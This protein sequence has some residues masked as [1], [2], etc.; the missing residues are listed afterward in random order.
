MASSMESR[1]FETEHR[2]T[3]RPCICVNFA[4]QFDFSSSFSL[5]YLACDHF[6]LAHKVIRVNL[7]TRGKMNY[8]LYS[9]FII[10]RSNANLR[11]ILCSIFII[12]RFYIFILSKRLSND[13]CSMH[14]V[15]LSDATWGNESVDCR[16]R[17]TCN[18]VRLTEALASK[19]QVIDWS[20]RA[21]PTVHGPNCCCVCKDRERGLNG[22]SKILVCC[23]CAQVQKQFH[24]FT[25]LVPANQV[26]FY[27]F[28]SSFDSDHDWL[29]LMNMVA[30]P[31][32]L[33]PV[34]FDG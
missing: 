21:V 29:S 8:L 25:C 33:G 19:L 10:T 34:W 9:D 6:D 2:E 13:P 7:A 15:R 12:S 24:R 30:Q 11:W 23:V 22:K 26:S 1:S 18:H 27:S 5:S 20:N 16:F 28:S 4:L 31:Q 32:H 3:N 14:R 17:A